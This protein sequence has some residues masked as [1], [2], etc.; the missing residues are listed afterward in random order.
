[1]FWASCLILK[2]VKVA[3][4][5]EVGSHSVWIDATEWKFDNHT[6]SWKEYHHNIC[7]LLPKGQ[8]GSEA[9]IAIFRPVMPGSILALGRIFSLF[10]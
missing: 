3:Q 2:I 8:S 9:A 1:M 6:N 5:M 10:G 4:S 7:A